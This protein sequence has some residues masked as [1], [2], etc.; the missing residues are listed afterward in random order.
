[1]SEKFANKVAR[2][3][4]AAP[5]SAEFDLAGFT[6]AQCEQLG[7][8]LFAHTFQVP[9][10]FRVSF[11]IGGGREVRQ[12]YD[13]D[14]GK[15]LTEVLR[16]HGF[17]E[18]CTASISNDCQKKFKYQ[19]DIGK[20][21]KRLHVFLS[22]EVISEQKAA[23]TSTDVC[24]TNQ[25]QINHIIRVSAESLPCMLSEHVN[26]WLHHQRA[27]QVLEEF[28]AKVEAIET[29]MIK[30]QLLDEGD[31]ELY[32]ADYADKQ[33]ITRKLAIISEN[34]KRFVTS[35]RLTRAEKQS[36]ICGARNKLASIEQQ[37]QK[38]LSASAAS[39]ALADMETKAAKIKTRLEALQRIEPYEL[40][41]KQE[42]NI[43][44]VRCAGFTIRILRMLCMLCMLCILCM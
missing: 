43:K 20:N 17:E 5:V 12:K 32:H 7:S 6:R 35:G 29:K 4:H 19:E 39:L 31:Y 33:V 23:T 14:L 13:V 38:L 3:V 16:E 9:K 30:V 11:V 41:L 25:D 42:D 34:M 36:L 44:H 18:D 37:M 40:K 24:L 28:K 10:Q 15:Y 2:A 21:L 8:E 22:C 1:M 26:T 27:K